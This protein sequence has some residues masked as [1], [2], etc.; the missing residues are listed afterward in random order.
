V[1]IAYFSLVA[2]IGMAFVAMLAVAFVP[3]MDTDKGTATAAASEPRVIVAPIP[4]VIIAGRFSETDRSDLLPAPPTSPRYTPDVDGAA[5]HTLLRGFR[6]RSYSV[7]D[8]GTGTQ[9]RPTVVL[10]HGAGRSPLSMIDMWQDTADEN[11][12]LLIAIASATTQ[13]SLNPTEAAVVL[14]KLED[15]GGRYPVDAERI[16]LFGHSSGSI[17]AQYLANHIE[18]PWRAV[19]GHGGTFHAEGVRP[20]ANAPPIRH[21]LGGSDGIFSSYDARIAGETLAAAGHDF[22]LAL[23]PGHTHWFYIGGPAFAADAWTWFLDL[24]DGGV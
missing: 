10:F 3:A 15:A 17:M 11:G 24:T 5:R 7:Y 19:A 18:G 13:W 12:L 20:H 16:F 21:Y 6:S 23:I 22:D 4:E 14:D 8:G 1:R 9:P 2:L